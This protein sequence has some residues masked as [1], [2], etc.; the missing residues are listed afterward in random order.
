MSPASISLLYELWEVPAFRAAFQELAAK[1]IEYH[2]NAMRSALQGDQLPLA[3]AANGA[4]RVFED[5]PT[6]IAKYAAI[7]TPT[8]L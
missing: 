4:I 1:E 5:L 2:V 3:H 6:T 8:R 7:Y